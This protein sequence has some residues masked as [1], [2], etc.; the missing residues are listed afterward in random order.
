[1]GHPI[2]EPHS[3]LLQSLQGRKTTGSLWPHMSKVRRQYQQALHQGK[4]Q[5]QNNNRRYM[6]GN[7]GHITRHEKHGNEKDHGADHREHHRLHHPAGTAEGT[8]RS[9]LPGHLSGVNRLTHDDRI[10]DNNPQNE[11]KGEQRHH[12]QADRGVLQRKKRPHKRN[13]NTHAN[14]HCQ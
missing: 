10:V 1:M 12:I 14:P 8:L 5:R 2:G 9:R 11:Q 13:A 7:T 3:Q 4:D 6:G